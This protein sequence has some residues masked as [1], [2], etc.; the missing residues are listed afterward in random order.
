MSLLSEKKQLRLGELRF[1]Q[2]RASM[3]VHSMLATNLRTY[4]PLTI[5]GEV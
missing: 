3:K 1:E 4:E 5:T 2:R